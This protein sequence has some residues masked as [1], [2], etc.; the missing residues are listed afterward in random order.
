MLVNPTKKQ[1]LTLLVL[2][3]SLLVISVVSVNLEIFTDLL[4]GF[5]NGIAVGFLILSLVAFTKNKKL[6]KK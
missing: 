6:Q 2:G 3:M 1:A 5:F 4:R